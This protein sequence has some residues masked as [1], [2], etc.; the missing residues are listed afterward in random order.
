MLEKLNFEF[1][2]SQIRYKYNCR[3]HGFCRGHSTVTQSIKYLRE[4]FYNFDDNI[5]QFQI[6]LD[7]A[8]AFDSFD[9]AI[10]LYKLSFYGSDIIF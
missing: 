4:L 2:Y 9:H 3:Q 5:E 6:Y 7:S 8:K 10:L 1:P